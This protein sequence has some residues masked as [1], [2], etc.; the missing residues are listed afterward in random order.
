MVTIIDF[1]DAKRETAHHAMKYSNS[2]VRAFFERQQ[3]KRT[4]RD[5]LCRECDVIIEFSTRTVQ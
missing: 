4:K 3:V 2:L 5:A 1:L